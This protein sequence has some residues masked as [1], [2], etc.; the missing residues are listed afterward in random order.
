M[1]L[2]INK[3]AAIAMAL[4]AQEYGVHIVETTEVFDI[5]QNK[6]QNGSY[7]I[8]PF[9]IWNSA[10]ILILNCYISVMIPPSQQKGIQV[11]T[12]M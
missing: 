6:S 11:N 5:K 9:I 2:H 1:L 8:T 12:K 10:F 3:Q 7:E 4:E